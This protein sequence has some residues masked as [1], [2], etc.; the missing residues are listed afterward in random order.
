MRRLSAVLFFAALTCV[1]P[2]AFSQTDPPAADRLPDSLLPFSLTT[3]ADDSPGMA[4]KKAA[5]RLVRSYQATLGQLHACRSSHQ[6][7]G[8]AMSSFDQRNGNT[9][10]L[11]MKIINEYGGLSSEIRSALDAEV[12]ALISSSGDCQVLIRE[13]N[14]GG[15][16]LYK[17]PRH[18]QDYK[19]V[20]SPSK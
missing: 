5:L 19:L 14:A 11:S 7:A 2:V 15:H 6:E 12:T 18:V 17:A 20:R 3:D 9:L 13:V 16:D 8:K 4:R 1:A 10:A